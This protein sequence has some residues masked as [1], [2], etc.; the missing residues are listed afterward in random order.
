MYCLSHMSE[1]PDAFS[2][3]QEEDRVDQ[4]GVALCD[5]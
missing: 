3:M 4:P 1:Q 2:V 5:F